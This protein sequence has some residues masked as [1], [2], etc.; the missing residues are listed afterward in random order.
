MIKY[1]VMDVDG[2]LTDGKIYIGENGELFKAFDVKDGCAIHDLLPQYNII[3]III[4]GRDSKILEYR[5]KELNISELYQGVRDKINCL[6][7][8]LKK[9]DET[10]DINEMLG[11][12]AYIGD[13]ILDLQCMELIKNASGLIACPADASSSVKKVAGFISTKNGGNG[14]VREFVEYIIKNRK[15]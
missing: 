12:V 4:T 10:T 9:Y 7:D 6:R 13:D 15:C 3:P 14:A 8:V 1:L 2:T 11:Q 5:C